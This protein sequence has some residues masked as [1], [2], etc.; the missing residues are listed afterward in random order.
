[1]IRVK[2]FGED[3]EVEFLKPINGLGVLKELGLSVNSTLI[4]RDGKPIPEDLDLEEG[5]SLVIIKSFSGG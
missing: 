4:L 1:M 2:I 5:D 3:R